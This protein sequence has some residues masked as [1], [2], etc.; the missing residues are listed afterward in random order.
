MISNGK[1]APY[2]LPFSPVVQRCIP[3]VFEDAAGFVYS[4][5]GGGGNVSLVVSIF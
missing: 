1:C 4:T 2:Y 5:A 3:Q